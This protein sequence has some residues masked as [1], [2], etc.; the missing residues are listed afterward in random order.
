M[1]QF[2]LNAQNF[3]SDKRS[4]TKNSGL[5]RNKESKNLLIF[6]EKT[7]PKTIRPIWKFQAQQ[8]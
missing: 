4:S 8:I 5:S 6:E 1:S 7:F 2:L 3:V